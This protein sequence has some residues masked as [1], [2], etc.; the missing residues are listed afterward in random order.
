[1]GGASPKSNGLEVALATNSDAPKIARSSL[2]NAFA[3]LPQQDLERAELAISELVTN[4]LLHGEGAITLCVVETDGALLIEVSDHGPV[5]PKMR[6]PVVS[7]R[8][9]RGL[10][11]INA[12]S[13]D[14]GVRRVGA[15]KTVW[16]EIPFL[17]FEL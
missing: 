15:R 12:L 5:D 8:H 2:R 3:H 11:A 7:D 1:M 10:V 16:C 4:A 17:G 6:N 13:K 9:G 14:W